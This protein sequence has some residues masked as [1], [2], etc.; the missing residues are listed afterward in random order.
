MAHDGLL[1]LQGL[2]WSRAQ[3]KVSLERMADAQ[4]PP[5]PERIE[6]TQRQRL[7]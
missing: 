4:N 7:R 2:A 5:D 6:R 3:F 1:S